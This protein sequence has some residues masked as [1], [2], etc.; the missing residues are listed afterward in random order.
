MGPASVESSTPSSSASISM[1]SVA[2]SP[3]LSG[4]G[5]G[6]AATR[7]SS[8]SSF[9]STKPSIS[10]SPSSSEAPASTVSLRDAGGLLLKR[11]DQRLEFTVRFQAKCCGGGFR[12]FHV[13]VCERVG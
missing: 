10:P 4:R 13:A 12:A 8:P 3:S 7:S 2:P 6:S 11:L 5:S 1:S 9:S